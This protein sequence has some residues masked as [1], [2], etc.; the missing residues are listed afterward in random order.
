MIIVS[1]G[2]Q[3]TVDLYSKFFSNDTNIKLIQI[4]KQPLYS[5]EMRNVA[6]QIAEGEIISYLDSDDVF[7]ANHLKIIVEQFDLDN[8]DFVYYDDLMTLDATFKK[9]HHRIVEP[10]WASIG[11]SSISHKNLPELYNS[12]STQY[13]HDFIFVIKLASL[14]LRY[15]KLDKM[16][17][18]IVCH[19]ANGDF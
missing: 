4:P 3:L 12:W 10:R 16:P 8:F 17:Q 13:G 9:F 14:G 7:G 15:K 11:T 19:Y 1:D 18:Y 6:F 2:C 5:G